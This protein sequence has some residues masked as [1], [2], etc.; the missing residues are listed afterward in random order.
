[1]ALQIIKEKNMNAQIEFYVNK[2]LPVGEN[3]VNVLKRMAKNP[4]IHKK[5]VALPDLHY[6]YGKNIPTGVVVASKVIIPS[7]INANCGMSLIKTN[8]NIK[9]ISEKDIKNIFLELKSNIV[10]KVRAKPVISKDDVLSIIKDGIGWAE[11]KYGLSG[12]YKNNVEYNGNLFNKKGNAKEV[13]SYLPKYCINI[14]KYS[15]RVLG[16]GNHFLEM[17]VVDK[18]FDKKIAQ[19]LGIKKGQILFMIHSDSGSFGL[20]IHNCF[21]NKLSNSLRNN[22]KL[23]YYQ[24]YSDW[25]EKIPFLK[26]V[27]KSM[28]FFINRFVNTLYWRFNSSFKNDF[29]N[30]KSIKSSSKLE[31]MFLYS[32][33]AAINYGYVNRASMF[34][35]LRLSLEKIKG[36]SRDDVTLLYDVNHDSLHK[37]KIDKKMLYLHRNG[38]SAAYPKSFFKSHKVFRYTGQ[39]LIVPGGFG[40]NSFICCAKNGTKETFYSVNHGSGR[41]ISKQKSRVKFTKK[42]VMG[43]LNK[44]KIKLFHLGKTKIEEEAPNCFKDISEVIKAMKSNDLASIVARTKPLAILKG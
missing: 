18:V 19:K 39:P 42:S 13:I 21:S 33:Y 7:F 12:S 9:D 35:L 20:S 28:H 34:N 24:I 36:V 40:S 16:V 31:K 41:V 1:M 27:V 37:E 38:A 23:A 2:K 14:G 5:I 10:P 8:L 43:R 3:S 11:K 29:N 25:L 17:Q 30:I 4:L 22:Y 6:K 15:L 32:Q 26:N 44:N